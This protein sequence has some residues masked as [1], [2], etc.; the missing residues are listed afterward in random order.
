MAKTQTINGSSTYLLVNNHRIGIVTGMSWQTENGRHEI[1]GIDFPDPFEI[2]EGKRYVG[3]TIQLV[4]TKLTGGAEG[5]GL[6]APHSQYELE[7][8]VSLAVVEREYDTTLFQTDRA[9]IVSQNW[10]IDSARSI[11]M[12]SVTFKAIGASS[13]SGDFPG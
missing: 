13:D 7:K 5:K 12:G 10:R 4:R 2:S 8:Y 3:G 1:Y 9:L 11:V 6:V